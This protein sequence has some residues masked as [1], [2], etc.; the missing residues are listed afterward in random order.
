MRGNER[1]RDTAPDQARR[2]PSP[3]RQLAHKV[4]APS[5]LL[6]SLKPSPLH[7]S[8]RPPP[9]PCPL[10]S[11]SPPR[12]S[13]SCPT[14]PP[15]PATA[16]LTQPSSH[17]GQQATRSSSLDRTRPCTL[18]PRSARHLNRST[19][20]SA[21]PSMP[22]SPAVHGRLT[23]AR[24]GK[25]ETTTT[26]GTHTR[27]ES[28]SCSTRRCA[29]CLLLPSLARP[30]APPRLVQTDA[31]STTAQLGRIA[32]VALGAFLLVLVGTEVAP[33]KVLDKKV[34]SPSLAPTLLLSRWDA[35]F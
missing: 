8:R 29:L 10:H 33:W 27:R 4:H 13:T 14:S 5:L 30:L 3:A 24:P 15:P 11:S 12:S 18:G 23:S 2:R 6:P 16:R 19:T 25:G 31:R 26:R 32:V 1:T 35:P 34:R 22:H 7:A 17:R 21:Q 28:P 20:T 9:R